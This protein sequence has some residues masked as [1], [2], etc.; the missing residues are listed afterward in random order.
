MSEELWVVRA[1]KG[2][3]YVDD[4]IATSYIAIGYDDVTTD[5]LMTL[6]PDQIR[7]I[8]SSKSL[9]TQAN[10]LVAFAYTMQLNDLVIVPRLV[11]GHRDYLVA[12]V[13]GP[14]VYDSAPS[15]W[16]QHRR[17]VT[18]LGRI[19][20]DTLSRTAINSLG[21]I[22]TIFRPNGA[23]AEIRGRLTSLDPLTTAELYPTFNKALDHLYPVPNSQPVAVA[24]PTRP[25]Q[26]AKLEIDVDSQGR[27][28]IS[29]GHPAL[30][31]EQTPRHVDPSPDWDGVPGI[32]VLTGTILQQ[33]TLR[34]G[35]ER[36]L[37]MT[38]I[39]RPWAYVGLSEN[40]RSRIGSH[41]AEKQEWRRA[42]LVRSGG[43]AFSS[44][45]IKY[46]EAKVHAVLVETE[47]VDFDQS[48]PRGNLSAQPR[49]TDMLDACAETVVAVLRLTGTL[50]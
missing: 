11:K 18:W 45:D 33:H 3:K 12:R 31:M 30:L 23:A 10:Q 39:V 48:T 25:L 13:I 2:A 49:N 29:S 19:P 34:T 15:D 50:I 16:G 32:Y 27:A 35:P 8:G 26:V 38:S 47:E 44:D 22:T 5:N 40:F 14:Y 37:T 7:A 6:D 28:T 1:G 9:R 21:G 20:H 42:L 4:V 24:A 46:L 36:T 43:R 41:R 17:L